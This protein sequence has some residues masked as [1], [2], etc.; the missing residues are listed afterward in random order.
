MVV[1]CFYSEHGSCSCPSRCPDHCQR[2]V[3]RAVLP[4]VAH[5]QSH[6]GLAAYRSFPYR[7][8]SSPKIPKLAGPSWCR[9]VL[10]KRSAHR[11]RWCGA[12][13]LVRA[14]NKRAGDHGRD[15]NCYPGPW[16]SGDK[17]E[18]AA[19]SAL[20]A[21]SRIQCHA[22]RLSRSRCEREAADYHWA[23]GGAGS[24]SCPGLVGYQ[25]CWR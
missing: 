18:D 6:A 19:L 22:P 14:C 8:G 15:G 5:D 9:H 20:A 11:S 17:G 24:S 25:W 1:H 10:Q 16:P 13:C 2:C 23:G 21:Y 12:G 4:I 3:S 7:R